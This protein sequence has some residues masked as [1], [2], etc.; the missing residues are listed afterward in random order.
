MFFDRNKKKK[1]QCALEEYGKLIN[2]SLDFMTVDEEFK[3]PVCKKKMYGKPER[4]IRQHLRSHTKDELCKVIN[5]H[6][7]TKISKVVKNMR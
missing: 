3:C 1:G 7:F 2:I 4:I 5:Y 6:R